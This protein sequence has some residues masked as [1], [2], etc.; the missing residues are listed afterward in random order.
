MIYWQRQTMKEEEEIARGNI[1]NSS[2]RASKII[3][4]TRATTPTFI[5]NRITGQAFSILQIYIDSA[6]RMVVMSS[7]TRYIERTRRCKPYV[8][9]V[10]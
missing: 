9:T 1:C 10:G 8:G 3:K 4:K 6:H 2:P 5:Q 7:G